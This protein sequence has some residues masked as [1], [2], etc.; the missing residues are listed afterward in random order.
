MNEKSGK[1]FWREL[2]ERKVFRVGLVYIVVGWLV[3][4]V[5]EVTFEALILPPWARYS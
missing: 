3:I 1:S 5:G 4:Q 2:R